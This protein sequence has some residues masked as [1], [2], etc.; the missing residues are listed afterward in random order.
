MNKFV[1]CASV[2][3]IS[4]AMTGCVTAKREGF[5]TIYH[6]HKNTN[7]YSVVKDE[8]GEFESIE[9]FN[10]KGAACTM[11]DCKRNL[12]RARL[13]IGE[14]NGK[15]FLTTNGTSEVKY[16][17]NMRM[18]EDAPNMY[19]ARLIVFQLKQRQPNIDPGMTWPVLLFN[20]NNPAGDLQVAF[21]ADALVAFEESGLDETVWKNSRQMDG[22]IVRKY[23]Q[24]KEVLN[25]PVAKREEFTGK[26]AEVVIHI[27]YSDKENGGFVKVYVNGEKRL[28]R[29]AKTSLSTNLGTGAQYGL[30][31]VGYDRWRERQVPNFRTNR[32][33]VNQKLLKEV[34][35]PDLNIEFSGIKREI[36][37]K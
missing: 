10:L 33:E 9:K 14:H 25:Y 34:D 19:P 20:L 31:L 11:D 1:K 35:V 28:D 32:W 18:N 36:I 5:G 29:V 8:T 6:V 7:G 16:S 17:F 23:I 22:G 30:Y 15:A 13:E 24:V 26:F 21:Q 12:E 2:L 3:A 27:K 4:V 37:S